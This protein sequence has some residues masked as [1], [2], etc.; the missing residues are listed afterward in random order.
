MNL[1]FFLLLVYWFITKTIGINMS[2]SHSITLV[3]WDFILDS[4]VD[5]QGRVLFKNRHLEMVEEQV[6]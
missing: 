5:E 1:G 2:A 6:N 4:N 3:R